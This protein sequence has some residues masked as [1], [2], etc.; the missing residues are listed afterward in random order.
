MNTRKISIDEWG[1]FCNAFSREHHGWLVSVAITDIT[2]DTASKP[3]SMKILADNLPLQEVREA[4]TKTEAEIMITVGEGI[5]ETSFL[6]EN[7]AALYENSDANKDVGMRID[8]SNR[9]S[10]VVQF[11]VAAKPDDLDGLTPTEM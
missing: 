9:T 10:T 5:D 11:R 1:K 6:V 7:V 4:Q 3:I 8:S 2:S